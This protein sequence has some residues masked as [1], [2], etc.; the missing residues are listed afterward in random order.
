MTTEPLSEPNDEP[1]RSR[2]ARA[3][4]PALNLSGAAALAPVSLPAFTLAYAVDVSFV[5]DEEITALNRDYRRKNKP[6]DVLSFSQL[7]GESGT[8][9][10]DALFPSPGLLADGPLPLGDLV[11]SIETAGRQAAELGHALEREVEF[12]AVHG[13]LHLLGYDHVRA[14]DRRLMWRWQEEIFVG[15]G[16]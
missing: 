9:G 11:I 12:L 15:L 3:E 6:T 10:A 13:A 4:K 8:S 16:T 14:A 5:S 1:K 7:E 2:A